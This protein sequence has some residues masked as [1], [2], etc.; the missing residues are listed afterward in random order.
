MA[1]VR[2][3]GTTWESEVLRDHVG[4]MSQLAGARRAATVEGPQRGADG[5]QLWNS[6]GLELTLLPGRCLDVSAA[7]YRGAS[8]CF[9]SHTGETGPAFYE[10]AGDGWL[11]SFYGGLVVTCGL[12]FVG[13]AETDPVVENRELG[14]HGRISNAPADGVAV[15]GRWEEPGRYVVEARGRM[16]E[17]AVFSPCLE[18]RRKIRMELGVPGFTIEDEVENLSRTAHSPLMVVY[19]TNPGF[20]LLAEGTRLLL[21]SRRSI[22]WMNGREVTPERY[23]TAGPPAHLPRDEV[24]LHDLEPDAAGN[25]EVAL[26]NDR[27]FGGTALTWRYRKEELP[28]LN[29]WQHFEAGCYVTGIEPGNCSVLG[30]AANRAAGTLQSIGPGEVRRFRLQMAVLEG[31]AA[32]R[33]LEG[34]LAG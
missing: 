24:Y 15:E 9:R 2:L 1:M 25:V 6:S 5:I 19:H 14:L 8:L 18:L 33:E 10:P 13:H 23:A 20:P 29:Q 17:G 4:D 27:L 26:V 21:R 22:E 11:R 3:F 16:R 34:R 7:T 28:I 32:I 12:T 31:T 30:R